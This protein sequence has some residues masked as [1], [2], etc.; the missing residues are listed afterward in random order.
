MSETTCSSGFLLRRRTL[1]RHH[2]KGL[3]RLPASSLLLVRLPSF[4]A[5]L[6]ATLLHALSNLPGADTA[7][8]YVSSTA[9]ADT[10]DGLSLGA[11]FLSLQKCV[12]AI[13]ADVAGSECQ[14]REGEY[15]SDNSVFVERLEGTAAQP[16]V[17]QAYQKETVKIVGTRDVTEGGGSAWT[18]TTANLA[19]GGAGAGHWSIELPAGFP[20]PW[21]LFVDG[22]VYM[23]ARWP[24]GR[25][26]DKSV[27]TRS[28]WAFS[29]TETSYVDTVGATSTVWDSCCGTSAGVTG[30]SL[31]AAGIDA[32]G[33]HVIINIGSWITY[34]A[35][36]LSHTRG[37]GSF[38]FSKQ[39]GW[40]SVQ[41]GGTVGAMKYYLENKLELL[42]A[43]MEWFYDKATRRIHLITKNGA[44]PNTMRVQARVQEYAIRSTKTKY[45]T[46]K[47]LQFFGTTV[48]FGAMNQNSDNV[49]GIRMDSLESCLALNS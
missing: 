11:P 4:L 29:A 46:L 33:A 42:D 36:V 38:T 30:E 27:F 47:N 24:N 2:L 8:Y 18:W 17:I 12:D 26:D 5:V 1:R 10:N 14:L 13:K 40:A 34:P 19:G 21:Q 44:N 31:Q 43:A 32:T 6:L 23:N 20:D 25:W 9:G 3:P 15:Y 41:T 16:Y 28:A 37:T 39:D 48:W 22:E 35:P 7:T 49:K 45:L